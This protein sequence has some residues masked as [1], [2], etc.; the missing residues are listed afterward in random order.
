MTTHA[1]QHN[2]AL[3]YKLP[4]NPTEHPESVADYILKELKKGKSQQEIAAQTGCLSQMAV[5]EIKQAEILER[6]VLSD[7]HEAN[8][9]ASISKADVQRAGFNPKQRL[10]FE[11]IADEENGRLILDISKDRYE[12][13]EE[14]LTDT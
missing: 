9:S 8:F 7:S 1:T 4:E 11:V 14:G 12:R 13:K 5:S 2:P 3:H 6:R 10:Y